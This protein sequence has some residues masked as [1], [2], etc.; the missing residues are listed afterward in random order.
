MFMPNRTGSLMR[1][2]G[3]N[4]EGEETYGDPV[5]IGL[6]VVNLAHSS[7]KTSVRSDSSASRGQADE[8]VTQHGKI[9]AKETLGVDDL[10]SLSGSVFRV[11]GMHP[12]YTVLGI[13]DHN[14]IFLELVS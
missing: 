2:T 4:L 10:L 14:E 8:M 7:Q 11:I 1:K 12:R 3:R 6:S 13:F 5:D 9:L